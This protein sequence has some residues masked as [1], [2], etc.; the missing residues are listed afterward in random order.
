MPVD[1]GKQRE[2][3]MITPV[4]TTDTSLQMEIRDEIANQKKDLQNI[5]MTSLL[6]D[7]F[8]TEEDYIEVKKILLDRGIHR[9]GL[10]RIDKEY[11]YENAY[12]HEKEN[13]VLVFIYPMEYTAMQTAPSIHSATEILRAYMVTGST[14]RDVVKLLSNRNIFARGHHPLGD[15]NEY[16]HILMPP[17]A[18]AAGLG[19]KGRTGLF[20]DHE[21]GP[22]VRIG[23]V[24][25]K[26]NL[27]V[28]GK[29][30]RGI[31][32]FCKRC[33]YC[34]TKCPPRAI[35]EL[36]FQVHL[37]LQTEF[38]FKIN[39][40]KCIK[41]FE[42]HHGCGR[43]VVRCVLAKNNQDQIMQRVNRIEKWYTTWI[44][45]GEAE[46]LHAKYL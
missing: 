43:C 9:V 10:A 21:L 5:H 20:I 37:N 45:T 3:A 46:R 30:I 34:V 18:V 4:G 28:N 31:E 42:R 13:T 2:L 38:T 44:K 33:L 36:N 7:R 12:V 22:M 24:S 27:P 26:S 25:L 41:Y 29:N 39:G 8:F 23:V 32:E 19:E 17:F 11:L 15:E 1:E 14:V 35:D 6:H 40:N 16:H